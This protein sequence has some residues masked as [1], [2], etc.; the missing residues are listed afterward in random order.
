[1]KSIH[2]QYNLLWTRTEQSSRHDVSHSAMDD[3]V[4][5]TALHCVWR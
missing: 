5:V 1:M 4:L 2:M 3:P